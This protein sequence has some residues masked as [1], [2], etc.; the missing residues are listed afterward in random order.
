MKF[1]DRLSAILLCIGGIN[2]GLIGAFDFNLITWLFG[3]ST[4]I[5]MRSIYI[6]IGI[7]TLWQIFRAFR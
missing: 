4:L 5:V 7:S 3:M 1:I 6:A 2:W